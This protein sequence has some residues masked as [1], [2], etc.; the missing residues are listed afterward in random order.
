GIVRRRMYVQIVVVITVRKR[1]VG[2]ADSACGTMELLEGDGAQRRRHH[3]RPVEILVD[4][5]LFQRTNHARFDV[6]EPSGW[7]CGIEQGLQLHVRRTAMSFARG[8][9]KPVSGCKTF[10]PRS[11]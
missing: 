10:S 2:R 6:V 1:R 7:P 11:R 4:R 5:V 8:A 3:P 9:A